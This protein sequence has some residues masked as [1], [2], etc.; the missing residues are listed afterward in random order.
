VAGYRALVGWRAHVDRLPLPETGQAIFGASP[1]PPQMA[2]VSPRADWMVTA[3]TLWTT[4][5]G[6]RSWREVSPIGTA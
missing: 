2:F 3:N 4:A 6:G 1:A 5:D